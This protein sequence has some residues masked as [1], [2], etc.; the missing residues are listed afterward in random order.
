ML[1]NLIWSFIIHLILS[2]VAL[3]AFLYSD[4]KG[5]LFALI[6]LVLLSAAYLIAGKLVKMR[7]DSFNK[8]RMLLSVSAPALMALSLLL[9]ITMAPG[10]MGMNFLYYIFFN[11]FTWLIALSLDVDPGSSVFFWT[12]PIPTLLLWIG[13]I[14]KKKMSMK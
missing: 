6:F 14:W 1:Y 11:P 7:V 5:R 10:P 12:W 2:G 8:K 9:S 13:L 4:N 3:T